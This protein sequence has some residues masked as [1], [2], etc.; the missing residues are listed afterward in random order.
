[1][2]SSDLW[3]VVVETWEFWTIVIFIFVVQL[4]TGGSI[5]LSP[6]PSIP[7]EARDT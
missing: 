7:L 2:M 4:V 6:P 3:Q 5:T 1:M